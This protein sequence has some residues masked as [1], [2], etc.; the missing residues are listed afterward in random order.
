MFTLT[1]G[2]VVV[3]P[4]SAF[5]LFRRGLTDWVGDEFSRG[6]LGGPWI[7]SFPVGLS[8]LLPTFMSL[9]VSPF[10]LV[11]WSLKELWEEED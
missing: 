4:T 7:P 1:L 8:D 10:E 11:L 3:L 6:G 5:L 2:D 9:S